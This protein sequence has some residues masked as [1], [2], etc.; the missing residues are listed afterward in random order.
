MTF[1]FTVFVAMVLLL[2]GFGLFAGLY[3]P[4]KSAFRAAPPSPTSF[5]ALTI[6]IAGACAGHLIGVLLSLL[7]QRLGAATGWG[8]LPS[9]YALVAHLNGGRVLTEPEL[10]S[11]LLMMPTISAATAACARVGLALAW[12][13]RAEAPGKLADF[14]YGWSAEVVAQSRAD[15]RY[16]T[17]FVLSDTEWGADRIGYEGTL[18]ALEL[19][20]DKEI[21][22]VLLSDANVFT[23]SAA[24]DRR[25]RKVLQGDPIERIHIGKDHIV[26]IAFEIYEVPKAD[27]ARA[28]EAGADA[29]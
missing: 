14:L 13:E 26:N 17:A 5:A 23:L 28:L 21:Q 8:L 6:V 12:H 7:F 3:L 27:V 19:S 9:P 4:G 16:I 1:S 10:L 11:F 29:G 22:S 25:E 18:D 2:P 20:A 24:G 15:N